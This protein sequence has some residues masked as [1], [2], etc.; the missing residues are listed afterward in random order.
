MHLHVKFRKIQGQHYPLT[1]KLVFLI[2]D[3]L[4]TK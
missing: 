2:V 1:G 3:I 4:V